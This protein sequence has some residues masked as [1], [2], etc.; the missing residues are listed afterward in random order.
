M[1]MKLQYS[2]R[3]ASLVDTSSVEAKDR[4]GALE[5]DELAD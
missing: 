2:F 1:R 4:G 5:M 3:F